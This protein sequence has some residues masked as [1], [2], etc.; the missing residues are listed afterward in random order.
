[1][2]AALNP[3]PSDR[4]LRVRGTVQGV[5]F[6]PFVLRTARQLGLRG[7][8]RNDASGVL[9]RAIGAE[10]QLASL[11]DAI[12]ARPPGAAR[13]TAVEWLEERDASAP[14][15]DFV[16]RESADP[17][18]EIETAAPPDLAPCPDCRREL[19]DVADRRHGYAFINCTQCGP[20]YSIL[21][22]LPY[23][24]RSTT[25]RCFRLCPACAAEYADPADPRFHAEPNACPACGPRLCLTTADGGKLADGPAALDCAAAL[26]GSGGIVAVKGVG[27]FHLIV[28]ATDSAAVAELRRR[29]HREEKPLAVL[30]R[31][32]EQLREWTVPTADEERLASSPQAPIVLVR[33]RPE[34]ALAPGVAPGNP[35][36][37]AL[38]PPSPLHVLLLQ[39]LP[40]PVVAT[41]ANLSEEP[42]CTDDVE[43]RQ[44][45]GGIADAFLGHD[46]AI[47]RP[48]D[49]S[50]VRLDERGAAILLRRARGYAP[51][52]LRLPAALPVPALCVGAQMKSTVAL[53]A[54]TRV[55]VSP[56]IGD[57]EGVATQEAFRRTVGMLS[58][59]GG[60]R[61]EEVVCDQHP[62]YASTR[63]AVALGL[64]VTGV[65]HHLAHVL[66]VLLEHG[67]V[68]D[69]VLGVA[70][71][72]TGFGA[73]GTVWGGEFIRLH[74]GRAARVARLRPFPL[75]GGDAA[76]RD[77]RRVAWTLGR[78]A[79]LGA[80]GELG[81]ILDLAE[82]EEAIFAAMQAGE[83][84]S[85]RC[86][87][88]GRLFDGIGALLG[89]GR[90]NRFEGQTALALEIAAGAGTTSDSRLPFPVGPAPEGAVWE[91]DWA[92]A[93]AA[94]W[95]GRGR[96]EDTAQ[97][98]HAGLAAAVVAV[99]ERATCRH[100]ALSGG[101]FQNALLL[102]LTRR[103]LEDAGFVV[104]TARELPPN[105]GAISAG[106]ALA[107]LWRL[108]TV[109]L[110]AGAASASRPV[111]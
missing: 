72:G 88:V 58:Q 69:D 54:G 28:D 44:R 3:P 25:M 102:R 39:R 48:V 53:A 63:Y 2:S 78:G 27:G 51:S 9:V 38:L 92:P 81:R 36:I 37:G 79:G 14:A 106:Q 49:D 33:A 23:D 10:A 110:P 19:A 32:L 17:G 73:D 85:P 108:T 104:L 12:A 56:H 35:W 103:A 46:R 21:E 98:F 42:L 111:R 29:K 31:D 26:L 13:V 82:R 101:C 11:A 65:Q 67:V 57:L 45:L 15:E 61:F 94:A 80:D 8:V 59:L 93:V 97:A 109:D 75:L 16:I 107:A 91:V 95:S 52:P 70:W 68:A 1:M 100:V 47:A 77:C 105:D 20:R 83:I 86:S 41:S 22:A 89:L 50:V 62:D 99:A 87:S 76:A 7:W 96:P 34:R 18:V 90:R 24:R 60:R 64:P 4:L 6:R 55:V 30:F 40:K 66:A 5:G 84:N 43:A 74:R 71:D